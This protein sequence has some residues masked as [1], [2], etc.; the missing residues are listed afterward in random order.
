M[1]FGCAH[2]CIRMEMVTRKIFGNQNRGSSL[3]LTA[4]GDVAV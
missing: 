3:L 2:V 1:W 4:E